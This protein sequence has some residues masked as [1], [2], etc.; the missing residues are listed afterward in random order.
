ME[1]VDQTMATLWLHRYSSV[2]YK[3]GL[4]QLD[5]LV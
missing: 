5:C 3:E 2:T 4:R 1:K